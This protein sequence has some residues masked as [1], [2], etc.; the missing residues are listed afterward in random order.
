M[1]ER[2]SRD[3][4]FSE[5][6]FIV[7]GDRGTVMRSED[8]VAWTF[9]REPARLGADFRHVTANGDWIVASS[10][11]LTLGSPRRENRWQVLEREP[12][13]GSYLDRLRAE[14]GSYVGGFAE[15]LYVPRR[16]T[17]SLTVFSALCQQ[18]QVGETFIYHI[19]ALAGDDIS[20]RAEGLPEGVNFDPQSGRLEG[21][22]D[23]PGYYEML[24]EA[25]S[26]GHV[27]GKTLAIDVLG[28][29]ARLTK[30]VVEVPVGTERVVIP[31]TESFDRVTSQNGLV[32]PED[33]HYHPSGTVWQAVGIQ[34]WEQDPDG[35]PVFVFLRSRA[36][37]V[38]LDLE[39]TVDLKIWTGAG[40]TEAH[41]S[42]F[43]NAFEE[44]RWPLPSGAKFLRLRAETIIR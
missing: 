9:D 15:G 44:I 21:R 42:P 10:P 24:V 36:D 14:D 13:A 39:Y 5:G 37:D 11:W 2:I 40:L 28:G 26:D 19:G 1:P 16:A 33:G 31:T 4:I 43:S 22:I 38:Q 27:H 20:Y 32:S 34:S 3:V 6:E 17:A 29:I 23:E 8:G 30:T 7:V 41:S 12:V 35:N 25:S 18:V